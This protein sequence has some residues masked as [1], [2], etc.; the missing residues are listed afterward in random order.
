MTGWK[1]EWNKLLS[2]MTAAGLGGLFVGAAKGVIQR[3]YGGWWQWLS[4]LFAATLTAILVGLSIHDTGLT[5]TQQAAVI[6]VCA[7]L[8]EDILLG[9]GALAA[10]FSKDPI[11][12]VRSVWDAIRGRSADK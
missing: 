3:R 9:L 5:E 8:A 1:D 11:G 7:F 2:L 6:G 4:L 12:T 10:L